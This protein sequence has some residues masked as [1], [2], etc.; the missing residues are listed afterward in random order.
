MKE[1]IITKI[2]SG[3]YWNRFGMLPSKELCSLIFEEKIGDPVYQVYELYK[4]LSDA[5]DGHKFGTLLVE[6]INKRKEI[7]IFLLELKSAIAILKGF[8]PSKVKRNEKEVKLLYNYNKEE[9][10]IVDL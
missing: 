3:Y 4:N 1:F 7:G 2:D 9:W 5:T 6:A 8:I 10:Q